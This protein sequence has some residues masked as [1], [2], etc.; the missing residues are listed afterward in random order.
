MPPLLKGAARSAGGFYSPSSK[1]MTFFNSVISGR[2]E[3][4][5]HQVLECTNVV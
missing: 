2:A 4:G 1:T 5:S 3:M